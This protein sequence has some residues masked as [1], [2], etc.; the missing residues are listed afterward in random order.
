[1]ITPNV[2][3]GNVLDDDGLAALLDFMTDRG[4]D[5]QFATGL[6]TEAD[7]IQYFARN[8]TVLG[9]TRYRG[10]PHAGCA[11]Y[12]LEYGGHRFYAVH[13]FYIGLVI[14]GHLRRL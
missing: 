12:Y 10:E 1:M 2:I 5:L 4:L 6:K 14:V 13:Y 9:H 11:G 7:F 8:P 3:F